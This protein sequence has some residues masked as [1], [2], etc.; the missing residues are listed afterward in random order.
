[1]FGAYMGH[2]ALIFLI[3]KHGQAYFQKRLKLPYYH[4]FLR[5]GASPQKSTLNEKL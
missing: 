2:T 4:L 1:M 5:K 3:V